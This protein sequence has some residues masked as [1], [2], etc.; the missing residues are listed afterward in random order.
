MIQATRDEYR[1]LV[2]TEI[3]ESDERRNAIND[4][5]ANELADAADDLADHVADYVATMYSDIEDRFYTYEDYS[6]GLLDA[7]LATVQTQIDNVNEWFGDRLEWIEKLYDDYYKEHLKKELTEKRDAALA[8]LQARYDDAVAFTA[9]SQTTLWSNMLAAWDALVAWGEA[10]E[11]AFADWSYDHY[12][13]T[14][15][16]SQAIHDAFVL[17]AEAN[18][19]FLNAA[20]DELTRKWAWWLRKFY[21]YKGY[22]EAVYEGYTYDYEDDWV[23]QDHED[24]GY[25]GYHGEEKEHH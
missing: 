13:Y 22:D 10:E 3:G 12:A 21:H 1:E 20:M 18:N 15:G 4:F 8:D 9:A 7:F 2:D 14:T 5:V 17:A 11:A 16:A 24:Y 23:K 25:G 6:N 19:D